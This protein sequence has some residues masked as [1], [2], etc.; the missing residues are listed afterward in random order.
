MEEIVPQIRRSLQRQYGHMMIRWYEAVD[1]TEPLV[2]GAIAFHALL[3]TAVFLARK[4]LA[5][6]C[7]LF[8]LILLLLVV[9]EPLNTWARANWRLVATQN[10]FDQRGVFIGIFY[11]GPLLA[12]GFFQLVRHY[13]CNAVE[14]SLPLSHM[15]MFMC[16]CSS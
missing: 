1:W 13:R 9:T 10:Y 5:V 4:R 14:C 7:G 6:Q 3:F 12:A 8:A 11:A 15:F 2:V 16:V